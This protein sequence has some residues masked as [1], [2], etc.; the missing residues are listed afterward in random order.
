MNVNEV[1]AN[2]AEELM[3]GSRGEYKF[4]HPNDHVNHNQSTNDLYPSACHIAIIL[5]WK[6]IKEGFLSLA[7]KFDIRG[8]ELEQ[9]KHLARTCLQDAVEITYQEFL[10]GYSSRTRF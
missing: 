9:V 5:K 2:I 3:G 8:K 6:S 10:S 7:E 4:V 1:L